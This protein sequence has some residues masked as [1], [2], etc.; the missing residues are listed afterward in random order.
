MSVAIT[1]ET[2]TQHALISQAVINVLVT[3]VTPVMVILVTTLTNVQMPI[4][5][6]QMQPVQI[7]M[8]VIPVHV[9]RVM[10]ETETNA[11]QS[12]NASEVWIIAMPTLL[13]TLTVPIS[14]AHVIP[15]SVEMELTVL[16]T[17]NV[18]T[19]VLSVTIMPPVKTTMVVTHA[20]VI[21]VTKV[22]A[23]SALT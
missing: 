20:A 1:D 17:T 21:P 19:E 15:A 5:V 13:A 14:V 23:S 16:T 10:R 11:L 2:L 9:T 12:T 7:L 3:T 4:C 18:P 22:M 6:P 8:E